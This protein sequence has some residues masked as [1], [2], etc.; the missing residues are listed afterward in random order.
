MNWTKIKTIMICFLVVMNMFL[1]SFLAVTTLRENTIPQPVID[2]SVKILQKEGFECNKALIPDSYYVLPRLSAQ[3]YSASSLSDLFFGKQ[4]AFRTAENSLVANEGKATLT[5]S[6][7]HFL[8]E[9]GYDA[10]NSYSY[11]E[12]KRALSKIG[13]NMSDAVY[14]ENEGFFYYMY[15]NVNLFNMYIE[16]KLDSDG[17]LCYVSAQWPS[18][19]SALEKNK[20][21][22]S[23]NI[24]SLKTHFPDGGNISHIEAGFSL[25]HISGEKYM[26]IPSF[27]VTVGDTS[28]I[29]TN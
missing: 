3:F 29:I 6:G 4:T 18:K 5:V 11:K 16:A 7:N 9:N 17:E 12:I 28:K 1:L 22:F 21:S 14:D 27:R 19:L 2:A 23:E 25:N 15:K 8:Y 10:D 13:I 24:M 26:F 20:I